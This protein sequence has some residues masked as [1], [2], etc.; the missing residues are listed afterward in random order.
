M[1]IKIGQAF[2][3][4][5]ANPVDLSLTLTKAQMLAV[6][7]DLMPNKYFTVCQDDGKLYMYDK[8][9]T[10]N[11]QTGK[12]SVVSGGGNTESIELTQAQYDALSDDEKNNGTVYFITDGQGGGGGDIPI[13]TPTTLG[14]VKVGAGL[15]V[16]SDGTLS[17]DGS[18]GGA[19]PDGGTLGQALVKKS[20]ANQ[21]LEWKAIGVQTLNDNVSSDGKWTWKFYEDR[22]FELWYMAWGIEHAID[23]PVGSLFK[24]DQISLTWPTEFNPRNK[25]ITYHYVGFW[26]QVPNKLVWPVNSSTFHMGVGFIPLSIEALSPAN[27]C[28]IR[29]YIKGKL[30]EQQGDKK[31]GNNI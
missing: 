29:A 17:A 9:A 13:A 10:P 20:N 25:S 31:Y 24:G 4:T 6:D 16:Q 15:Q 14:G 5:S 7:D 1:A 26:F 21:D 11:A 2:E 23:T 3:R 8:N 12:Y 19:V 18:G 28:I 27:N 30:A 22:T